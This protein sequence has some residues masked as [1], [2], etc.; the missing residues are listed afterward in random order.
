[1]SQN[2]WKE[3]HN[4]ALNFTGTNDRTYLS[5]FAKR[6]PR[7]T[8]TACKCTE[9]WLQWV[10]TNPPDFT[11]YFEWTVKAH[12]AISRKLFKKQ[13]TLEEAKKLYNS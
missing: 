1:M 5:E 13:Y 12:N 8:K 10:R 6:I 9:F 3:L 7:Y 2:L 11:N 4:H